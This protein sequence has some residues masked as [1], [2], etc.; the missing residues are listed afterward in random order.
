MFSALNPQPS[1]GN[2]WGHHYDAVLARQ[3][4]KIFPWRRILL[5]FAL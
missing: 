2:F 3:R 5:L 1:G 4:S